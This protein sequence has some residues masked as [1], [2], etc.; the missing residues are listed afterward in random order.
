LGRVQFSEEKLN[1]VRCDAEFDRGLDDPPYTFHALAVAFGA[2]QPALGGPA[3]IAVHDDR[4]MADGR[5]VGRS[6][7]KLIH[8][9]RH[10]RLLRV[11]G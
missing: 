7:S 11:R 6:P 8:R 2:R 3:P 10:V 1:S 5:S 4:D 9:K